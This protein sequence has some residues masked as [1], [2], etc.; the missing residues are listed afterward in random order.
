[1]LLILEWVAKKKKLLNINAESSSST[2]NEL[3]TES[4]Y[5]K[6]KFF[7]INLFKVR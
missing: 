3:R 2:I 6:K 1:M 4:N 7:L 5:Y